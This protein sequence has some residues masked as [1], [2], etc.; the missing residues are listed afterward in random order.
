MLKGEVCFVSVYSYGP[1]Y[2]IFFSCEISMEYTVALNV[3]IRKLS[4]DTLWQYCPMFTQP[5]A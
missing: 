2:I 1:E 3:P 4:K 5:R